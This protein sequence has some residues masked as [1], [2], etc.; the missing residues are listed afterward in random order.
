MSDFVSRTT[1]VAPNCHAIARAALQQ[2]RT[3]PPDER[4]HDEDGVDVRGHDLGDGL[5]IAARPFERRAASR[6][7]GD[8][9]CAVERNPVTDG[10]G[11]EGFE[12]SVG[13][14]SCSNNRP[15]GRTR[16][17]AGPL[18]TV[19]APRSTRATRAG[20]SSMPRVDDSK[21]SSATRE[22]SQPSTA[23]DG[24]SKEE[25]DAKSKGMIERSCEVRWA[26]GTA[27][28]DTEREGGAHNDERRSSWPTPLALGDPRTVSPATRHAPRNYRGQVPRHTYV[29]RAIRF[30]TST[31]GVMHQRLANG[32]RKS[33]GRHQRVIDEAGRRA[34]QHP[35]LVLRNAVPP[36]TPAPARSKRTQKTRG[37]CR[38]R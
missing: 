28:G 32:L 31:P 27:S 38:G 7:R 15:D 22:E 30:E 12:G 24:E 8:S 37:T 17:G 4:R 26:L 19:N 34:V 10:R 33:G 13:P 14:A 23:R 2:P 35:R 6:Y 20:V 11:A 3:R 18:S 21:A 16:I 25:S 9:D 1:G 5:T 29:S 36:P